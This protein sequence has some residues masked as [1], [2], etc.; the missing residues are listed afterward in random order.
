MIP[1][2][3]QEKGT[4]HYR[5]IGNRLPFH[6]RCLEQFVMV[7]QSLQDGNGLGNWSNHDP[8]GWDTPA[9]MIFKGRSAQFMSRDEAI[10]SGFR[11]VATSSK[12]DNFTHPHP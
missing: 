10:D 9:S 5:S 8:G 6:T 1:K 4:L 7:G 12:L 11:E 3:L 2:G